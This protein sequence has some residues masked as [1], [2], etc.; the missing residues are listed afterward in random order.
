M[1]RRRR[2]RSLP[3]AA[4]VRRR[5]TS[6]ALI[7]RSTNPSSVPGRGSRQRGTRYDSKASV[8]SFLWWTRPCLEAQ[9]DTRRTYCRLQTGEAS[10]VSN[11]QARARLAG[12]FC[13]TQPA[14]RKASD[15]FEPP[16]STYEKH[17]SE[18]AGIQ[19]LGLR[20][21]LHVSQHQRQLACLRK[22]LMSFSSNKV[23]AARDIIMMHGC[24]IS[25][26]PTPSA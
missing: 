15:E 6:P 26:C 1:C 5:S 16:Q 19:R 25:C 2:R 13:L 7:R 9:V 12:W 22:W 4:L 8:A 3:R 24:D 10:S 21:L 17:S 18:S 20:L 11:N 23:G 14:I